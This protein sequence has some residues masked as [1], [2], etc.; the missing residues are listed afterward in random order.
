[1]HVDDGG[2]WQRCGAIEAPLESLADG[3][4]ALATASCL[5]DNVHALLLGQKVS[6]RVHQACQQRESMRSRPDDDKVQD[7]HLHL[8]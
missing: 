6:L 5:G 1:M 8:V 4:V 7:F 2:S 3:G